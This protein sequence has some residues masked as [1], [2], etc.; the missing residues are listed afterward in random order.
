MFPEQGESHL[1]GLMGEIDRLLSKLEPYGIGECLPSEKMDYTLEDIEDL[2]EK[3]QNLVEKFED[4]E[5]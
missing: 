4:E 5:A 2:V 3:L 1:K